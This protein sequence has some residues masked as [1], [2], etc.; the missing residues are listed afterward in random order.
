MPPITS[1]A[2]SKRSSRTK[3]SSRRSRAISSARPTEAAC[4]STASLRRR[5]ALIALNDGL[6]LTRQTP[7][8]RRLRDLA[9]TGLVGADP[10]EYAPY[11]MM[12]PLYDENGVASAPH[13]LISDSDRGRRLS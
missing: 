3:S 7:D 9:E 12:K 6:G 8:I 4:S 2:E 1:A 13:A 11:Y 5:L 10:I